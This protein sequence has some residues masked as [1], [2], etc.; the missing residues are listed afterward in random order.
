MTR[1]NEWTKIKTF[2]CY[3]VK[4]LHMEISRPSKQIGRYQMISVGH[5]QSSKADPNKLVN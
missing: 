4:A 1:E 3:R 5:H 2:F